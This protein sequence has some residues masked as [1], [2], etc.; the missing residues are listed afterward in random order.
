MKIIV[1]LGNPGEKY[2]KTRHNA[3]FMAVDALARRLGLTWQKNKKFNA[4][5]ANAPV[6]IG[7]RAIDSLL[8]KGSGGIVLIK[9]LTYMNNSGQAIQSVLSYYKLLPKKLGLIKRKDGDLSET[10]TVIHDDIDIDLGKYK[11]S[12]NSRSGGHNGV[13]S[14]IDNLKTKNFRRIRIGVKTDMLGKIPAD[15][16]VLQNFSEE[17]LNTINNLILEIVKEL[18]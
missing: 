17:E 1:G 11:I 12:A 9:P 3:G 7:S 10:L 5:I 8:D 16:F 18:K 14:I 13:Q 4:E 15:K 2:K 6:N